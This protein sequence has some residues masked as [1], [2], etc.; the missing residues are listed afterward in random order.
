MNYQK[1]GS[2]KFKIK[3]S[4]RRYP[5]VLVVYEDF[6]SSGTKGLFPHTEYP[7]VWEED[8]ACGEYE[9]TGE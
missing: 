2:C 7:N 8:D 6:D 9:R 5:P 4:C 1:C 3:N